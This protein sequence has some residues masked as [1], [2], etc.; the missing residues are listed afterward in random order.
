MTTFPTPLSRWRYALKPASWPKLLVPALLGVAIGALDAA[1]VSG[2]GVAFGALF[3]V[4]DLCAI[5][6]LNDWADRDVDRIKRQMFPK[7]CSPKTIPDGILPAHHVLF[8]GIAAALA[9]L[10]VGVVGAVW[11][12]LPGAAVGGVIGVGI[13]IAYSLPPLRLNYRGGGELLEM[14]GVGVALPWLEAHFV[15]GRLLTPADA[16]LIGFV[17]LCLASAIA[18]GLSDEVSD[19]RGGKRTVASVF[20]NRLARRMVETL[21]LV[22]VVLWGLTAVA[23]PSV[24]PV[25]IAAPVLVVVLW[26][27]RKLRQESGQATTNAFTP[28]ARYKAH[29]HHAIWRGATLLAVLTLARPWLPL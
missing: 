3:V 19:R 12:G 13:F 14:A 8:A 11:L 10:I 17:P 1:H 20:G 29:L 26:S 6:L 4:F 5:V 9:A 22:G 7:G 2:R 15:S 24:L 25:W 27:F 21:V 28:Q 16:L 23:L 18:S